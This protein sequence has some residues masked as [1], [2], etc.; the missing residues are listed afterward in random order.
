MDRWNIPFIAMLAVACLA[1]IAYLT[2][3][4][5]QY[6]KPEVG[7]IIAVMSCGGAEIV[8]A[9]RIMDG[10]GAN[11]RGQTYGL[12]AVGDPVVRKPGETS[13]QVLLP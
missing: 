1:S 11:I 5:L 3:R 4:D 2:Q 8:C 12:A 10:S 9:V 7:A 13:W 6:S